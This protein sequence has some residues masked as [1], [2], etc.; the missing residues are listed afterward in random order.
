MSG[1][2]ENLPVTGFISEYSKFKATLQYHFYQ[3]T[4]EHFLRNLT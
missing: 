3:T 2:V 1:T 4:Y